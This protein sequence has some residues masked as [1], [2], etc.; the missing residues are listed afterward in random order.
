MTRRILPGPRSGLQA[1]VEIPTSKSLTNRALIA[2]AAA[3]GGRIVRPLD[4]EDTRLLARALGQAGWPVTWRED[5][6]IGPRRPVADVRVDLGNSGT[7]SR[8]LL[9]LLSCVPGRALI[10]GTARLRQRPMKPLIEALEGL[11]SR[12]ESRGGFLPAEVTGGRLAGGRVRIEPKVSSQFVSALLL[13]APLMDRG[14]D[15]EIVGDLPSRPYLDLTRDVLRAFGAGVAVSADGRWR[16][17]AGGLRPSTYEV[18]GDWSAAAFVAAAVGVAGGEVEV[19]PLLNSSAQGDRAVV[20]IL[21]AAGLDLE[22][23]GA[24]LK[25]SGRVT[26][27]VDADLTDT[28]DLFPALSV[29]AA[30]GPAGAVLKGLDHLKHKESDRLSVMVANLGRLGAVF[31][32]DSTVVRVMRPLERGSAG[33]PGVSSAADHRIAMAMAVAALAAGPLELDDDRCVG[34]SFPGFWEMWSVLI[35]GAKTPT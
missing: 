2:A 11:G 3:G 14:I 9:G 7:G 26:R 32:T 12:I 33:C 10:D 35:E 20:P 5:V 21:R 25:V 1:H 31:D 24:G 18:E 19:G 22:D 8:L 28:P 23:S 34:K 17:S 30:T 4:C 15:L 6:E 16:V 29:V 27:P 13:A